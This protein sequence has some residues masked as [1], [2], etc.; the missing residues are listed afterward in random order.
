M[1]R[2][3][4]YVNAIGFALAL[5]AAAPFAQMR[6]IPDEARRGWMTHVEEMTV[7]VNGRPVRLAPGAQIRDATNLIVLPSAVPPGSLVKF[8]V[9]AQGNLSKVW[10]LSPAEAA[11]RDRHR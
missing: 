9:D 7:E 3:R 6:S 4:L 10:I 1:N 8:T 11:Q 5:V 2:C